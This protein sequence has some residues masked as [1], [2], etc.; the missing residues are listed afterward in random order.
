MAQQTHSAKKFHSEP[1]VLLYNSRLKLF[2]GKLKSRWSGHFRLIKIYSHAVVDL[3]DEKIGQE[4]MVN[5]QRI[6][7]YID[8]VSLDSREDVG[9][10]DPV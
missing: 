5:G 9:F 10:Y 8:D 2:L 3:K 1:R 7:H 4:F 6:K